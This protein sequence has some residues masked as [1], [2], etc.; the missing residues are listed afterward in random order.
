LEDLI[1]RFEKEFPP[2]KPGPA[3][4][5]PTFSLSLTQ[6]TIELDDQIAGKKWQLRDVQANVNFAATQS[7]RTG[8]F[9]ALLKRLTMEKNIADEPAGEIAANLS[10]QPSAVTG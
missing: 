10:W 6:G 5:L 4:P 2:K 7:P 3:S 8:K 1:A 9:T